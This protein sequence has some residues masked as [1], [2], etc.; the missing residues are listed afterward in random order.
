MKTKYLAAL[1]AVIASLLVCEAPLLAAAPELGEIQL[2]VKPKPGAPEVALHALLSAAGAREHDTIDALNVRVIRVP[3]HAVEGLINALERS[4]RIEYVEHDPIA[5]T[6]AT[7]ND[8][9]FMTGNQWYLSKIEAP[10]AW[11]STTGSS[12]VVVAV[13]DTGVLASHPDMAGKVIP[14]YDFVNNDGDPTDDN[15]HGTSVAGLISA[16][17]HNSEGMAAVTWRSP[18]L[19]VKVLGSNGSGSYSTVSQGITWATDQG[20][21]IINLSLGGISSSRTL[22]DAVNYA[23]D[24]KVVI[25]AAAGN[26]GDDKPF[27]PAA[28]NNVVAVSATDSTDQR[29][30][31]SNFGGYVDVSAPG[32]SVLTLSGSSGYSTWNGTS[33]ASPVAAGVVAL[34]AAA[35]PNFSNALLVET[36]LGSCDDI[37]DAGYDVYY[38]HGRVNARRAVAAVSPPPPADTTAPIVTIDPPAAGAVLSGIVNARV[39]ATDDV[40]VVKVGLHLDGVLF[41]ESQ[42]ASADFSWD[43]RNTPDGTYTLEGRAYDAA[44]NAGSRSIEVI[45]R[46]A[47]TVAGDTEAPL[48]SI[49]SPSDGTR[50]KGNTVNVAI[51]SSDNVGVSRVEL[52]V[53]G[54]WFAS[55][56]SASP[57]F[58][59]N[60]SKVSKG[61]HSLQA[62]AYDAAGN[63]GAS[64]LITVIK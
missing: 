55:S 45:V 59:W 26:N 64:H 46:N 61:A 62:Y 21:R 10:A 11:R 14:G 31:W 53:N 9:H 34:M 44:N 47:P 24:R 2:L 4:P 41:G 60:I 12:E 8:P 19:A 57:T 63:I 42:S 7:P 32:V 54:S 22:Q 52:F 17:T 50:L 51:G 37:G 38:G 49:T 56:T 48:V 43:T 28:C 6:L 27:F 23:W 15:G 36:L 25:I 13:L 30:S 5:T 1:A 39:S 3:E 58:R 20:A 40:G 33:Y 35:N 29:P 18:V 16:A